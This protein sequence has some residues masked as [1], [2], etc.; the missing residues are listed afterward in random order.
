MA[1]HYTNLRG[2]FGGV[3]GTIIPFSRKLS[4][5][6]N[7][8]A[9]LF[10]TYVPAGFLRCDGSVLKASEYP[11]LSQVL[12]VGSNNKFL[13]AGEEIGADEFKLPDLGSKYIVGGRAQGGFLN[14]KIVNP[15]VAGDVFRVGAEV[16]I[17][18]LIG[19]SQTITYEGVFELQDKGDM[20][21][22]GQ[23]TFSTITDDG[24][25]TASF[26]SYQSWQTH[27][28]EGKVGYHRYLGSW[29]ESTFVNTDLEGNQTGA[30][31]S[32][33]GQNEGSNNIT[34][35]DFT[36]D[37]SFAPSH[38]HMVQFPSAVSTIKE[39]N[40]LRFKFLPETGQSKVQIDPLGLETTVTVTT[41][42]IYK[43][44]EVTPPYFLVEYI[45]KV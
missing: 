25:T 43:L 9:N 41:S 3:T 10:K 16:E 42:N 36:E 6:N 2:L 34:L 28:H 27:G 4:V 11:V 1:Q 37:T 32:N 18:S 39:K 45:I 40:L 31:G 29:D 26:L 38:K 13:R 14:D 30:G 5:N 12:G 33:T 8:E 15:E 35:L 22:I 23:P 17:D 44:D 21:F 19:E 20:E 24:Q 7:P